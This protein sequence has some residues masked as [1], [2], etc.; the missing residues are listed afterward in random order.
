MTRLA[1]HWIRAIEGRAKS[2]HHR[3]YK[4]VESLMAPALKSPDP[5]ILTD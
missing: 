2:E 5:N 4:M 3:E 1:T